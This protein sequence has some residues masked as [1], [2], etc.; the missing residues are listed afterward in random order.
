MDLKLFIAI[1]L[2]ELNKQN[3]GD[4]KFEVLCKNLIIQIL[5]KNFLGSSG[6]AAGGDGALDGWGKAE[7]DKK[8]KYAFSIDQKLN[9][10]INSEITSWNKER[11]DQMVFFTNQTIPQRKK[12]EYYRNYSDLT[13]N[14]YDK[15][16]LISFIER[17]PSLGQYIGLPIIAREFDKA[18]L[19]DKHQFINSEQYIRNFLPR[20]LQLY[21]ASDED[22]RIESSLNYILRKKLSIIEAPAGFGKTSYLQ[23]L[24]IE[25]LDTEVLPIPIFIQLKNYIPGTLR[26][27]LKE[28][29]PLEVAEGIKD[30]ILLIDGYDEISEEIRQDL[31]KELNQCL[32]KPDT[33]RRFV[34]TVRKDQY[35]VSD[36]DILDTDINIAFITALNLNDLDILFEH[37]GI[38]NSD[39][40]LNNA[41]F[42]DSYHNIFYA[43]KLIDFYI[44]NKDFAGNLVTLMDYVVDVEIQ[45]IFRNSDINKDV[46]SKIALFLT[47]NQKLEITKNEME[48]LE[49]L[50]KDI[51]LLNL[52]FSHKSIQE[53]LAAKR[54]SSCTSEQIKRMVAIGNSIIPFLTNTFGYLLNILCLQNS[55][56]SLFK[57]LVEWSIEKNSEKLIQIE[58]DK[59]SPELNHTIFSTLLSVES[60][61]INIRSMSNDLI[62]FM[63][64]NYQ[65]IQHLL[66]LLF[67]QNILDL[68]AP[69]KTRG[70]SQKK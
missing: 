25:I 37:F 27:H 59:I 34:I 49:G 15:Q 55:S 9:R 17:N 70:I 5:D 45:R 10:K 6:L 65:N 52:S 64:K 4:G 11:Y 51:D 24:Y 3:G 16:D 48:A 46:L 40:F 7:D 69:L 30:Y 39:D 38:E 32:I 66:A 14:L 8:I 26:S 60:K 42:M 61:T 31:L 12:E 50:D 57:D 56:Y 63:A 18:K 23:Q 2:N 62:I 1:A 28:V 68:W 19:R 21:N 53:Y 47:L 13:F 43:V 33:Y 29:I 20:K 36:F 35:N 54:L 22:Q 58:G 41:F 67:D 44:I